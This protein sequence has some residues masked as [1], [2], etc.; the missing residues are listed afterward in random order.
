MPFTTFTCGTFPGG[1]LSPSPLASATVANPVILNPKG[2]SA[3]DDS[4]AQT[5]SPS[6]WLKPEGNIPR[7]E[8]IGFSVACS[9]AAMPCFSL[10]RSLPKESETDP[11]PC[12][13]HLFFKFLWMPGNLGICSL[14][15]QCPFRTQIFCGSI[16]ASVETSKGYRTPRKRLRLPFQT[17]SSSTPVPRK[18]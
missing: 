18:T 16:A 13:D 7:F 17:V 4:L 3:E 2:V 14:K 11:T 10:S 6:L 1:L 12:G 15:F 9:L 8:A 5:R